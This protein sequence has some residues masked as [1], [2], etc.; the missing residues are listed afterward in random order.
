MYVYRL[1]L[2]NFR[3]FAEAALDL[4]KGFNVLIGDNQSGKTAILDALSIAI[5]CFFQGFRTGRSLGI[6]GTDVRL[7]A[8]Q[9]DGYIEMPRQYPVHIACNGELDG[10]PIA[11]QRHRDSGE[12]RTDRALTD[13]GHVGRRMD[14]RMQDGEAFDLP[15]IA[16]FGT[17]RVARERQTRSST[18]EGIKDRSLAY[19]DC[20][21]RDSNFRLI[22]SWIKS[23]TLADDQ[24]ARRG[25]RPNAEPQLGAI[26]R[27]ICRCVPGAKQFFFDHEF[28]DLA[29]VFEDGR[30]LPWTMLSD[31]V[32][33]LATL[34]M[35]I[36]WRAAILNPH[37]R[38]EAPERSTGVVLIDELDLG[39][40]P[41][42][43]R[44]VVELLRSAFPRL[45]FVATTHSPFIVQALR[46]GE[47]HNLSR[48]T[49]APYAD[50]SIEDIAE[51]TMGVPLPQHSE[52]Y[53]RMMA[54]AEEYFRILK[55]GKPTDEQEAARLKARLDALSMPFSDDPAYQ[56]FLKVEREASGYGESRS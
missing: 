45:Q 4:H 26:E 29:I 5:S 16:Y 10:A 55:A 40:H 2:K 54:A 50:R 24:K 56:A 31:G 41:N 9:Q 37:L 53:Q 8:H 46:A 38:S 52:R 51:S 44:R 17:E 42:W 21:E 18:P 35:D 15:V 48:Q 27:T 28:E 23:R 12:R 33:S 14:R 25:L 3:G 39:L 30:R 11:W 22:R 20:L 13:L 7:L 43:Q 36:S 19:K 47:L 6:A 34:A 49:G 1:Q 32:I